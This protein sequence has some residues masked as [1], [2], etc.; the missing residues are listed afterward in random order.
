VPTGVS[1][2]AAAGA[3]C[4]RIAALRVAPASPVLVAL[5]GRSGAGKST[6]AH[7]VGTRAAA[8][9]IDG[10]DFYRGGGDAFWD[11]MGPAEKVDLVIDW[12]RQ[13]AVLERLRRGQRA[14]WRPYDWEAD[15]GRPGKELT[16]GP[17]DVVILDGA[18]SARPQLADLFSLHALLDVPRDARRER[19]LRREGERHRA[20]WE[21]RWGE[22]EDLYFET[23]M[24][25]DAFDLVLDGT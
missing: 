20:E 8:L 5:D 9:V 12:R 14:Q 11:A 2:A 22:A 6:V 10:D 21:A 13:R 24:P 3:L 4:D 16:A 19:L 23:M 17:A 15:D 18:Y 7:L 25:P 1:A